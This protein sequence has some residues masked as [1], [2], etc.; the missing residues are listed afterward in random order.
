MP[1]PEFIETI[2]ILDDDSIKDG[3]DTVQ[4]TCTCGW[5]DSVAGGDDVP[6]PILSHGLLLGRCPECSTVSLAA[7]DDLDHRWWTD[8]LYAE[9]PEPP[10]RTPTIAFNTPV[11]YDARR[12]AEDTALAVCSEG[13]LTRVGT[14]TGTAIRR[15]R[16]EYGPFR[17]FDATISLDENLVVSANEPGYITCTECD[18]ARQITTDGIDAN[19]EGHHV[20]T[21]HSG[22]TTP[23]RET[24][25]AA[26]QMCPTCGNYRLSEVLD[27]QEGPDAPEVGYEY[28]ECDACGNTHHPDALI[29]IEDTRPLP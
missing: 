25:Q 7:S 16:G 12:T 13:H 15:K 17:T 4:F 18:E 28:Y 21:L 26:S 9:T 22:R 5:A 23:Y 8:D 29:T 10:T 11:E 27:K 19:D 3:F 24:R 6:F 20:L 1:A 2:A 14:Y